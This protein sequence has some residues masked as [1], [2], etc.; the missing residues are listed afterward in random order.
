MKRLFW[1]LVLA[2]AAWTV[3]E[4]RAHGWAGAFGGALADLLEPV[5]SAGEIALPTGVLD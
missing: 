3:L 1:L 2:A 4:V 5:E